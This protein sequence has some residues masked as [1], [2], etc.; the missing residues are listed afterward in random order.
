MKKQRTFRQRARMTPLV[1]IASMLITTGLRAGEIHDAAAAGDLSK[2][3][4]LLEADPALLVAKD[5]RLS[6]GGN[7]PLISACWGTPGA[8][9]NA[10]VAAAVFLIDKGANINARNDK[11]GTPLYSATRDLALTQLLI[12]KGASVNVR[13]Y[14]DYT[15]IHQAAFSGNLR[16][17]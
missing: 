9:A 3:K 15:P 8:P 7:T 14:G 10:Q 1:L 13:A 12:I 6:Y 16:V 2:I 11:G 5:D 17:A 4:A